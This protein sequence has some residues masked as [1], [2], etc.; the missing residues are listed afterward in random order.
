MRIARGPE[1]GDDV[2]TTDTDLELLEAYLDDGLSDQDLARVA[3][4]LSKEPALATELDE[5]RGQR[6]AR[7]QFFASLEPK[8]G[9]VERLLGRIDESIRRRAWWHRQTAWGKWATAAA[10]CLIFGFATGWLGRG[11]TANPVSNPGGTS[12]AGP[13]GAPAGNAP[14]NPGYDVVLTNEAGQRMAVQHFETLEKAKEFQEDLKNWQERAR[15]MQT[16]NV[17][18]AGGQF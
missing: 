10:A 1:E 16:G 2:M 6:D 15:Q 11:P 5:L 17:V 7:K 3:L 13:M 12:I 18:P 14:K 9:E 8:D 4:R